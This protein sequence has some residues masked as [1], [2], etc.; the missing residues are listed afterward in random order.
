MHIILKQFLNSLIDLYEATA[1]LFY[2]VLQEFVIVMTGS[3]TEN[4]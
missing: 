2:L 1:K 4:L 3:Q